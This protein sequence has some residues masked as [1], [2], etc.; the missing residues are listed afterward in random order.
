M[1]KDMLWIFVDKESK[2]D[3]DEK[4]SDNTWEKE[5]NCMGCSELIEEWKRG[6]GAL[7]LKEEGEHGHCPGHPLTAPQLICIYTH[8]EKRDLNLPH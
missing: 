6:R 5:K 8:L 4:P 3:W 2:D 1:M 7:R